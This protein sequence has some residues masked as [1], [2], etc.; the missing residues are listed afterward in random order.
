MQGEMRSDSWT[1]E[2]VKLLKKL[3]SE[4]ATAAV[5]GARLG[6]ISR[7]AV[8]GK[9]FRLRSAKAAGA[10]STRLCAEA[11]NTPACRRRSQ[12][13]I[14]PAPPPPAAMT[15]H[16]TL[17]ELTNVTCRWPHGRPGTGRFFFCGVPVADLEGRIPYCARHM[18]RA[19]GTSTT[20]AENVRTSALPA[21]LDAHRLK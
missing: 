1:V 10:A 18:Q 16:K 9:V 12:P 20:V 3:W 14:R 2:R 4:G 15:Q 21:S 17:L 6:G 11:V 5:I 7:S 8:M 19:Y 13:R